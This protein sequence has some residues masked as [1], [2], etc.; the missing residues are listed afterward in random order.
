[1]IIARHS[2]TAIVLEPLQA[3][4]WIHGDTGTDQFDKV[5]RYP[6]DKHLPQTDV[7]DAWRRDPPKPCIPRRLVVSVEIPIRLQL[8]SAVGQ[9]LIRKPDKET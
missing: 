4:L 7:S 5:F 1:V 9:S 8:S 2:D 3:F 6:R